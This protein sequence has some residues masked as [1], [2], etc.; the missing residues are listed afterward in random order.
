MAD[1]FRFLGGSSGG[2]LPISTGQ[3]IGYIRSAGKFKVQR[4]IQNVQAPAPVFAYAYIDPDQPVRIFNRAEFVWEDGAERPTGN[5]NLTAYQWL[6][7]RTQRLDI[8]WMLGDQ[9]I[10][11]TRKNSKWD[12]AQVEQMQVAS[13]M[14]TLRTSDVISACETASSWGANTADANVVNGGFGNWTQASDDP[15]SPFYL[16]IRRTFTNIVKIITL[17]TNA[18]VR[19]SDIRCV[20][21][22]GAATMMANTA[23][24]YNYVKYGP[25]SEPRQQGEDVDVD[26]EFGLPK[27]YAG[28]EII[29]EDSPQV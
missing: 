12:P 28:I 24:I 1:Q 21:S 5:W 29:V 11:T 20:I 10:E 27:K 23:E 3:I 2:F 9:A 16:A 6:T 25:Y 19:C 26:E 18:T 7:G 8:P 13:Q 22:P 14:M 4:Y 15:A 17:G